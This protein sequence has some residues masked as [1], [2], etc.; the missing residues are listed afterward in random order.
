MAERAQV[1]M[2]AEE[3][4]DW[5]PPEE[6]RWELVDG[7]PMMMVRPMLMHDRIVVNTIGALLN[8]LGDAR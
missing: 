5:I 2:T 8:R 4:L 1:R 6:G 7:A 3:F